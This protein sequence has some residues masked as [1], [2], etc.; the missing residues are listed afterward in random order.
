L[1]PA[2][3]DLMGAGA[4]IANLAGKLSPEA[5]MARDAFNSAKSDLRELL[6]GSSS[7]R[8]LT[9]RGFATDVELA[10][11]NGVSQCVPMLEGDVF[12]DRGANS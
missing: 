1:R 6:A 8:E 7:G 11:D 12:V 2:W 9:E 5:R 3:E 10:A 4:V